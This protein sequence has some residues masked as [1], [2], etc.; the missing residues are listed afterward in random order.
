MNLSIDELSPN[1][2]SGIRNSSTWLNG[3]TAVIFL[4]MIFLGQN[5]SKAHIIPRE[6]LHPVAEAYRRSTFILNLNPVVWE[7]VRKDLN[8]ITK[9][10]NE[11]STAGGE[12]LNQQHENGFNDKSRREVFQQMT[13]EVSVICQGHLKAAEEFFE[14]SEKAF[15][16]VKKAQGVFT[17]FAVLLREVDPG[18]YY[19]LGQSWLG[20]ANALGSP[21]LLGVGVVEADQRG[22]ERAIQVV[23]NYLERNFG[24]DFNPPKGKRLAPW[25]VHSPTYNP[26]ARVSVRLPPGS[27][28]NK[29][30][31]RPRQIL[32]MTAR[33]VDESETPLIAVGDM[34]FD[35]ALIFGEPMRSI[36][37]SCNNCH[38]KSITNPNFFIPGLS[39]REGGMDVS[40]SFFA[41]HANNGHFD[42]LDIPD[43]RGIRFTTPY[44]RNGRFPSLREFTRNVIVNEFN[45]PEP[46]PVILDGMVAY[47]NEF[48]FLPNPYLEKDGRLAE[49]S[50][51]AAKRGEKLFH[52]PYPQMGGMSCASCHIPSANFVDHKR[53]DIGTVKGYAPNSLDRAL[54]TPTLLGTLWSPPYFHDGSQ[55][56]LGAVVEWFDSTYSLNLNSKEL[57]ELT[58][59]LE[60]VGDGT[61]AYED[62]VYYLDAEMEE[63]SFFLSAYEFLESKNLQT[64]LNLT[65][66]TIAFEIR[67]HQ[68]ELQDSQYRPILGRLAEIMDEALA[69]NQSGNVEE[70]RSKVA[71]YRNLYANN[72]EF[73]K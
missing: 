64:P 15:E 36:G 35:S 67:N 52:K 21:G 62:T 5:W 66:Q 58:T 57:K 28:I 45:G 27:N 44:G 69:A 3:R 4:V 18:G 26:S 46:D 72:V 42:P 14:D 25:P 65:F 55:P 61:D 22:F 2:H 71:E 12:N 1:V 47:M 53:H 32:N 20:M 16:E 41:P 19:R 68:W 23:I 49:N 51:A 7:T 9:Y 10:R 38:N 37:M 24:E 40:N 59:Y 48:D 56:T 43:L 54:D 8:T 39:Q 31:P 13:K 29:Q 11:F 70:V 30:I 73:L 17:A 60:T 6:N 50:L 63:F 33:G 34:A